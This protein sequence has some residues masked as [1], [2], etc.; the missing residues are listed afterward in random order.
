MTTAAS[1]AR[2]IALPALP[3]A[4]AAPAAKAVIVYSEGVNVTSS[5][6]YFDLNQFSTGN[7]TVSGSSFVG[8]DAQLGSYTAQGLSVSGTAATTT[9]VRVDG[10][11]KAVIFTAGQS[12][13]AGLTNSYGYLNSFTSNQEGYIGFVINGTGTANNG[14]VNYGWAHIIYHPGGS[15]DITLI[16]F[17]YETT[18]GLAIEAGAIPEPSTTAAVTAV[19]AGSLALYRRRREKPSVKPVAA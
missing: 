2:R 14:T 4:L 15:S 18:S 8:T 3:I 6:I 5:S 19:L 17:A 11:N 7:P 16:D 12:I 10:S 1:L 9:I 13:D